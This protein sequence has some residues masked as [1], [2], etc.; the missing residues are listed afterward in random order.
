VETWGWVGRCP[1]GTRRTG[2]GSIG[3]PTVTGPF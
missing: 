3:L 1:P 2:G